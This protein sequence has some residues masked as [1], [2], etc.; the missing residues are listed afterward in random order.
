MKGKSGRRYWK[1][2]EQLAETPEFQKWVDDEFP[3]RR[4]L[5]EIDRRSILKVM[6]A[7]L[8]LAGLSASGCRYLPEER[9]VPFISGPEGRIPG[10]PVHYATVS[11]I[12]GYATGLRV[13]TNDGRPIKLDGNPNHPSSLGACDARTQARVLD[14]YDPDR[15]RLVQHEGGPSSWSA[16]LVAAREQLDAAKETGGAGVVLLT[17]TV[18]SPSLAARIG[19]F[20]EA[21]PQ[22]QWVQYEPVN[23]DNVTAG[24]LL[25]FGTVVETHYRFDRAAVIVSLDSNV[26][27]EGPGSVRY[28]YDIMAG[29]NLGLD[30]GRMN[31]IYAIEP[32]PTTLGV[33]ADHRLPL[34]SSEIMAF[35]KALAGKLGVAGV[36]AISPP[37]GVED[38]WLS[39]LADDLT[40]NPG[41][42]VV[43]AGE[44]QHKEVHALVHAINE[45]LGNVGRTVIHTEPVLPN[46]R[47]HGL[48]I[49]RLAADMDRGRVS[50]LIVIEGNPVYAAPADLDFKGAMSKVSFTAHLSSHDDET[51]AECDWHLP[52]SHFLESWGDGRGHDGTVGIQQPMI[53]P[54]YESKSA[55]ELVDALVGEARDGME[56][57]QAYWKAAWGEDGFEREWRHALADGIIPDSQAPEVIVRVTQGLAAALPA[58]PSA[59]GMELL[60]LPDPTIYDGRFAN[61]GW[62]QE[63]PK[64]I[65]NLTWDNAAYMSH[66][67]ALKLD[68]EIDK[69]YGFIPA[70]RDADVIAITVDGRTV[71]AAVYVNHGMADDVVM[72]HFG[73][74]R[75]R[76]GQ[77][78]LPLKTDE[79]TTGGGFNAYR[80]RTSADPW[81]VVGARFR[82]TAK[83]YPLANSQFH[84]TIDMTPVDSDRHILREMRL[85]QFLGDEEGGEIENETHDSMYD[86]APLVGTEVDNE[87]WNSKD[88][89]QWA[90]TVDLTLCTGCNACVIACQSENNIPT[91]G[92]Y[93]VQRGREMHW[94]R[95]DRYYA[96]TGMDSEWPMSDP[97]I[98]FQP[99]MC[100]H[101]EN[102]PC[103]P[104][105]PV[106]ATT[107]SKEGLNQMVYNRCVGTRYCSNNCPYKVRRFNFLNYANHFDVPVKMLLNNPDVTVRSRGVME[108]CTYCVQRISVARIAAKKAG[109]KIQDGEVR[110]ACQE[111]C[112]SR[113][114]IFGDKNLPENAVARSIASK[115]G[116]KVLDEAVNTR[117]RTTY[118]ARV[119]NPNEEIGA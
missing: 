81:I 43:V 49:E 95:I 14:L 28:Q 15:L 116:Y 108:K 82:R 29:R 53:E 19:T 7:S 60:L 83:T 11:T 25:A 69:K 33:V 44:H 75:E 68:I 62:L 58:G 10:R 32:A 63:L 64:P 8:M 106:A 113:A 93:Q 76:G 110:T 3:H 104:V 23:R 26:M 13:K 20:L 74:G 67:T 51:C 70:D 16:F 77:V 111:A 27:M 109:G 61:N 56:A 66:A 38:R 86:V 17:E 4:T 55:L 80:L 9:L 24:G 37:D 46:P 101:C 100:Q 57:V 47:S 30:A 41:E 31:R 119:N 98:R 40:A 84:N 6:G 48:A 89:Y 78:M 59:S 50:T 5:L 36:R 34:K 114:I 107:H 97:D 39:A 65:S 52:A 96:G 87:G 35:A 117:P 72:L 79:T 103:E 92:K 105:C 2:L 42:S 12:G 102:A 115:R 91:V 22:A 54:L 99:M 85:A 112:P 88:H 73:Y 71:E 45:H 21:Y 90:M 94:I 1:S 118:L 18:G